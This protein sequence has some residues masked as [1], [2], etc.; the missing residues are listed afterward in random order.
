MAQHQDDKTQQARHRT[1]WTT[2]DTL[3]NYAL[4]LTV[5]IALVCLWIGS[6]SMMFDAD[7]CPSQKSKA[8]DGTSKTSQCK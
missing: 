5:L 1:R 7:G 8:A 4:I 2:D 3:G 6:Q